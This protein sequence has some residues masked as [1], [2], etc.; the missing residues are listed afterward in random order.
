MTIKIDLPHRLVAEL[1][2]RAATCALSLRDWFMQ[3]AGNDCPARK[4]NA[5]RERPWRTF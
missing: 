4:R 1:E 2:V 5:T 3:L